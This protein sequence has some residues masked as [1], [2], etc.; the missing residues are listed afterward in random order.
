ML[1]GN[2]AALIS[3]TPGLVWPASAG[4][5]RVSASATTPTDSSLFCGGSG[6][7]IS[8][9]RM[10]W[11]DG[12]IMYIP[13]AWRAGRDSTALSARCAARLLGFCRSRRARFGGTVSVGFSRYICVAGAAP[14]VARYAAISPSMG[15]RR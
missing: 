7:W 6:P 11:S 15:M 2:A 3:E 1:D 10:G 13:A 14:V 5:G 9:H 4:I 12:P 8:L